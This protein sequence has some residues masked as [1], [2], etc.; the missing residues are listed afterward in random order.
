MEASFTPRIPQLFAFTALSAAARP[1]SLGSLTCLSRIDFG[2]A[3]HDGSASEG[4]FKG[5]NSMDD[6]ALSWEEI[7]YDPEILTKADVEW[8]EK[9]YIIKSNPLPPHTSKHVPSLKPYFTYG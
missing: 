9:P 1:R 7:L 4:N 6:H 2:G 8:V 3:R 5:S